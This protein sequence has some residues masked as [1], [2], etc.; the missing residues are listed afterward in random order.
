MDQKTRDQVLSE[1]QFR[2]AKIDRQT[3]AAETRT[4]ALSFSSENAVSRWWGIEILSHD[5]GAMRTDRMRSGG[6]LLMDHNPKD[7][8]GVIE[9]CRCNDKEKRGEAL[10]RFSRSAHAEEILKDVQDGIRSNISV[11][12]MVHRMEELKADQMNADLLKM[13]ADE[14]VPVFRIT[15]WEPMEISIVSIPADVSVGIGRDEGGSV[16][17]TKIAQAVEAE[18]NK[19]TNPLTTHEVRIMDEK[20][21]D[22][23]VE[24]A[25]AEA[26]KAE[27]DRIVAINAWTARKAMIPNISRARDEAITKGWTEAMFKGWIAENTPDDP[28]LQTPDS[29]LGLTKK[30]VQRYSIM[31][32]IRAQLPENANRM[33]Q[34]AFEMECHKE[35]LKTAGREVA[36]LL[37]PWEVQMKNVEVPFR[38]DTAPATGTYLVGTDLKAA[39]FIELLR[40]KMLAYQLGVQRLTGLVGNV[41]IPRQTG[42]NTFGWVADGHAVSAGTPVFDQVSLAL[43]I[44]GGY[45]DVTRSL[46]LQATPGIEGLMTNDLAKIC[47]IGIDLAVFHGAGTT[48]PTGLVGQAGVGSFSAASLDW[49]TAQEPWSDVATANAEV[50]SMAWV[51]T[52]VVKATLKA[53]EKVSGYPSFMVEPDNTMAGY[54]VYHTNQVT[55]NYIFFGDFSQG[56]IGEWGGLEILV[57]PYTGSTAGTVRIVALVGIDFAIRHGGAFSIASD[58]S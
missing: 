7:Q 35:L 15:D 45:V 24:V 58:F 30:E 13:A 51:T 52:P 6:A 5:P 10:A 25:K 50:A 54:P 16:L 3:V 19:R 9:E 11:G 29:S 38:R 39:S 46:I 22:V 23:A 18:V 21:K 32:L 53:R 2:E 28:T 40:N 55:A 47:A 41:A 33:D 26:T 48:A 56:I 17:D 42:A 12:Y 14:K 44:G 36:G 57:D 31:N 34:F 20:E 8:V 49:V 37:V 1:R 4:V 43:N 27:Q